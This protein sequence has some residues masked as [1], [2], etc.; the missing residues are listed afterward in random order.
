MPSRATARSASLTTSCV[1]ARCGEHVTYAT[2]PPGRTA[3]SADTSSSRC[4]ALSGARSAGLRRQRASGRR[5]R[6]PSPVHGRVDHDP[7]EGAGSWAPSSRPSPVRTSSTASAGTAR[8]ACSTSCVRCGCSSL[9]TIRA[10]RS[11]ATAASSAALPP[12]PA[13]RSSQ[14]SSRPSTGDLG[15]R[16]RDQLAALVL[17]AGTAVAH[18]RQGGRVAAGED[19]AVGVSAPREEP[20][21]S[22]GPRRHRRDPAG[23][24]RDVR[25]DVVR[26]EQLLELVGRAA[27][28]DERLTQRADDPERVALHGGQRRR[29]RRSPA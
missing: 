26:D 11:P 13:H 24:D 22:A 10:P 15:Q 14:R 1:S 4:S 21:A 19:T 2:T 12:G 7:V 9:A 5:R 3:R 6:A 18:A 25:R 8:S 23:D 17:H 28:A 27:V 20:V 29:A 16:E